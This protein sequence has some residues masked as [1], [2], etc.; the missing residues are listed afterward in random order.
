MINI[1]HKV[2]T[3]AVILLALPTT[4]AVGQTK[5]RISGL[6]SNEEYMNLLTQSD[7]IAMRE[8][9]LSL[10]LR[11]SRK[12]YNEGGA[13]VATYRAEIIEFEQRLFDLR[14][15]KST[16][17]SDINTI[18]QRWIMDHLDTPVS[19]PKDKVASTLTSTSEHTKSILQS[20]YTLSNLNEED[21]QGLCRAESDDKEVALLVN[22]YI[23]NYEEMARLS[24]EYNQSTSEVVAD[25]LV[26]LHAQRD[27]VNRIIA[28]EI[29]KGWRTIADNKSF[30]YA[31][32]VE[33]MGRTE[34][35]DSEA[36]LNIKAAELIDS[37][38]STSPYS[39]LLM[40]YAQRLSMVKYE[41]VMARN[42][43]IPHAVDSLRIVRDSITSVGFNYPS[44][45]IHRRLFILYE[46]VVFASKSPY[47]NAANIP[48]GKVYEKGVIYRILLGSFRNKQSPS[49]F[50]GTSPL[51]IIPGD[52]D[53]YGYYAGGYATIAEATEARELLLKRGFRRP[54]IVEWRD[55][56]MRNLTKNP[57]Q[58]IEM[59]RVEIE[60]QKELSEEILS[61]IATQGSGRELS[62]IGA[63]SFVVGIFDDQESA[64]HLIESLK[65]VDGD[66]EITLKK[67]E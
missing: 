1:K 56:E 38:S 57:R 32:L 18:E 6:E 50:R 2:L 37:L 52:Y 3:L 36:E 63:S 48:D 60:S 21:Y 4:I 16:I 54:E 9:S 12:L 39:D 46:P 23:V 5:A 42:M 58:E 13:D 28:N 8:D 65:I 40:Y 22:Q 62:K 43:Q 53:L 10:K 31:L 34:I 67:V 27:S 20:H 24:A 14:A 26:I 33:K 25:S 66:I 55:G 51:C 19:R 59:F 44:A 64:N 15:R 17:V 7:S 45:E 41:M 29:A 47:A 61:V 11:T 35:F 49:L 30:A